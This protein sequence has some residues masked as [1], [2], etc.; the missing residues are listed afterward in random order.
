MANL[1]NDPLLERQWCLFNKGDYSTFNFSNLSGVREHDGILPNADI[2]APE[3]WRKKYSAS[4]VIV[5]VVDEGIE[6]N[7][8]DLRDNIWR[9][10]NKKLLLTVKMIMMEMVMIMMFKAGILAIIPMIQVR[11]LR[12]CLLVMEPMLREPLV[13]PETMK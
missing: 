4:E 1:P 3:A 6:V 12:T 2:R 5:A 8:P 9:N 13:L 7:H 11:W 10:E